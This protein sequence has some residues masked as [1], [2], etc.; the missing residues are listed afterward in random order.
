MR[1]CFTILAVF[2]SAFLTAAGCKS[3][4]NE[5]SGGD[6]PWDHEQ[7][8]DPSSDPK[9]DPEN[10][11]PRFVWIDASANFQYYANSIDN[12]KAD[13]K[14]IK[15]MGFTDIVVDVRP[16]EGTVLF[17][18]KTAPEAGRLAAWVGGSY[19][20]VERTSDFDYLE[21]FIKAGKA[22]GLRVNAAINTFVCGYGGIYGLQSEGPVFSGKIPQSWVSHHYD[23]GAIKS[24]YDYET[25][26]P[27]VFM[28]PANENVRKYM[29]DIIGELAS[30]KDLDGIIL[31]R[32]R[33]DDYGLMSDF[34]DETRTSFEIYNGSKVAS[35][36]NDVLIKTD[37][38]GLISGKLTPLQ[39]KWLSFR[40]KT[41]HDF[42]EAASQKVHGINDKMR[43]GC[44]VGAWYSTYYTSGVNWASPKYNPGNKY[45]W[46]PDND[47]KQAG[48]ADH[49]DIMLLG[50]YA[51]AGSVYGNGEWTMQGFCKQAKS[52][53]CGD[54]VFAGG[55]DVGNSSG[56]EKG[57]C[58][59]IIPSTV[60]ACINSADGYFVFD[61]CHIRMY[62]Y[63]D[64]FKIGINNYLST[65]NKK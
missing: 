54:T 29:L 52:I 23:N 57:G 13:V 19:R 17:K 7:G 14:R 3:I 61:L 41:I 65:I 5:K 30:Y 2:V 1:Y 40:V 15:E 16:T 51:A 63:W 38:N 64:A 28:N 6:W 27:T 42:V 58:A 26:R 35:W 55:P 36:P 46:G 9:D 34:S 47:Y 62:N 50:C 45:S 8:Q 53:L 37:A 44:Y 32:C 12:I 59:S 10:G 33:F 22:E 49:C 18:S 21:E 60:D 20:F 4:D 25:A 56:F 39:K 11:K 31:D 43:F 24:S 48:Y